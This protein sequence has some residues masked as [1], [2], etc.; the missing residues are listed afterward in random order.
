LD[1]ARNLKQY[2]RRINRGHT[3]RFKFCPWCGKSR[4]S[5]PPAPAADDH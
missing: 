1:S 3:Q 4:P 5:Q 2:I